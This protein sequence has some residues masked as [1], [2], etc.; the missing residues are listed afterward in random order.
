MF[1]FGIDLRDLRD[2][3]YDSLPNR[4]VSSSELGTPNVVT[5][6]A[7]HAQKIAVSKAK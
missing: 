6:K 2:S 4:Q 5:D 3:S 1:D 7:L